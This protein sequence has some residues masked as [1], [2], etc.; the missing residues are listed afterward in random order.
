MGGIYFQL[1]LSDMIRGLMNTYLHEP[2][3]ILQ[4]LTREL[5]MLNITSKYTI[6]QQQSETHIQHGIFVSVIL[7]II[8]VS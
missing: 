7:I 2:I 1:S 5:K 6:N 3:K 4:F 8:I